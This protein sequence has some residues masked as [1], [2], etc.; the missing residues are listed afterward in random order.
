MNELNMKLLRK[1]EFVDEIYTNIRAFKTKLTLF[2]KEMSNKSFTHFHTL[3]V[4]KRMTV[5]F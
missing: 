1:D 2:L 5:I 4:I 3:A